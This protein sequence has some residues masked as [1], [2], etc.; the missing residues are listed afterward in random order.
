ML[1]DFIIGVMQFA[2]F[3]AFVVGGSLVMNRLSKRK[4]WVK[5]D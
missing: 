2:G 1:V 3:T 4:G 5:V